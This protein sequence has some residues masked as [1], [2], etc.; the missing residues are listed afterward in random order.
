MADVE[1]AH[2]KWNESIAAPMTCPVKSEPRFSNAEFHTARDQKTA[3]NTISVL[4]SAVF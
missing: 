3:E 1:A 4:I 2:Q